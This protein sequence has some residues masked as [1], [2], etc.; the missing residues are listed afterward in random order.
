MRL[1]ALKHERWETRFAVNGRF[2]AQ[3]VTGVQRYAREIVRALDAD[4]QGTGGRGLLLVPSDG[5]PEPA[6]LATEVRRVAPLRGH[7]WEQVVLAA[8][9]ERPLLNLCNTAPALRRDQVVC[10]HDANVFIRPESYSP[11]F[12][13]AYR[14]LLPWLARR[15]TR[16]TTVSKAAADQLARH[17]PIQAAQIA[18]LPN[19]HEHVFRW[20]ESASA[21]VGRIGTARPFVLL[22][23]SLARHK[24][25]V[26]ILGLADALE[27]AGLDLVIAGG[28]DGIFAASSAIQRP[29]VTHLGIVTDD[30]LAYLYRRALCLAFP[31]LTEGF[32]LPIVEAMALGCPVVSSDRASMPEVCGPAA[33]LAAPDDAE[34]W[35]DHITTLAGS[36][37]LRQ[38]L[39]GRGKEQVQRFSWARSA[40]GYLDLFGGMP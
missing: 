2:T 8:R 7:A 17:L 38:D 27:V 12:R 13:T 14:A 29:N 10:I 40:R 6:L 23:G 16:V 31:S 20:R 18:I 25:A 3:R 4:L 34:R 35:L 21:L 11:A 26:L 39:I 19:G 15:A 37:A 1:A 28:G 36:A 22:L 5:Q 24:N 32:G 30:D 9:S 33:L